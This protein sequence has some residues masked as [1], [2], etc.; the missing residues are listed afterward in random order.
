MDNKTG[1]KLVK[2]YFGNK[3]KYQL[4]KKKKNLVACY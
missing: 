1:L 3:L 2:D 4:L